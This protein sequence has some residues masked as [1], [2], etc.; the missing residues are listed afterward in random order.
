MP[1]ERN[2]GTESTRTGGRPRRRE[3][4]GG[5]LETDTG[6]VKPKPVQ[7]PDKEGFLRDECRSD[8][9]GEAGVPGAGFHRGGRPARVPRGGPARRRLSPGPG[10]GTPPVGGTDPGAVGA[11]WGGRRGGD[12]DVLCGGRG[13]AVR[14]GGGSW[15]AAPP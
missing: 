6:A 12:D 4:T 11:E 2:L 13:A 5:R 14:P 3:R 1:P 15:G 9:Q 7:I 8:P 10:L